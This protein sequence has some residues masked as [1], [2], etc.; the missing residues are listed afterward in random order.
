MILMIAISLNPSVSHYGYTLLSQILHGITNQML[1][2]Q[3]LKFSALLCI[4]A[5]QSFLH[6]SLQASTSVS[7]SIA[8]LVV[9][10]ILWI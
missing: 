1:H 3:V 2:L 4:D 8:L 7:H 5:I 10:F 9:E 6:N